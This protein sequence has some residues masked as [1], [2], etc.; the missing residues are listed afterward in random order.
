MF[1]DKFEGYETK[2]PSHELYNAYAS[3]RDESNPDTQWPWSQDTENEE[4][5][6]EDINQAPKDEPR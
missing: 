3:H 4:E 1:W 5:E 6:Q 2:D